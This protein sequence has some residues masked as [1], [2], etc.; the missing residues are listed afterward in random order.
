MKKPVYLA[1]CVVIMLTLISCAVK[2]QPVSVSQ[3][4]SF[5]NYQY[6]FVD[7]Y[8]SHGTYSSLGCDMLEGLLMKKGFVVLSYN[9]YLNLS[10]SMARS[11]MIVRYGAGRNRSVGFGGYTTNVTLQFLSAVTNDLICICTA[12]GMGETEWNDVQVALNRC[13]QRLFP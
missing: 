10:P 8:S 7:P 6:V 11:T 4:Q 12:E 1:I 5:N 9:Q 3:R 2:Y 13:I